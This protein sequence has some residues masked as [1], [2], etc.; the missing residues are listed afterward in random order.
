[1]NLDASEHYHGHKSATPTSTQTQHASD[2]GKQ[3][4]DYLPNAGCASMIVE[5]G[6]SAPFHAIL[7]DRLQE[8]SES[9]RRQAE[10]YE[11]LSCV[12][13]IYIAHSR[14]NIMNSE[15]ISEVRADIAELKDDQPTKP[16]VTSLRSTHASRLSQNLKYSPAYV[17]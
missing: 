15:E 13:L 12:Y 7:M 3:R 11:S 16:A 17:L 2:K 9:L 8:Q 14:S 6:M 1:M 4:T 5:P 10:A